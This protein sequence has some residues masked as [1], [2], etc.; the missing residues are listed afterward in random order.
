MF[1]GMCYH[2]ITLSVLRLNMFL[3]FHAQEVA[4]TKKAK[5]NVLTEAE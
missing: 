3:H 4:L 1:A 2:K 5:L